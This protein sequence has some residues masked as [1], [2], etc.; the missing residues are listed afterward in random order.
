M[1]RL[2][3]IGNGFDLAHKLK[4][5]YCDFITDY[6]SNVINCFYLNKISTDPL[7]EIKYKFGNTFGKYTLSN[8][9]NA[10]EDLH[11]LKEH[12]Y[13]IV[14][15]KSNF[16]SNTLKKISEISWVDLEN[17]YFDQLLN[18]KDPLRG[19][20]FEKVK[21]LNNEFDF[22]KIQLENY[23]IK[24]QEESK[25]SFLNE[26]ANLF[27]EPIKRNDIATVNISDR[28]PKKILLLNFNYTNTLERYRIACSEMA[29]TEINYIHGELGS[30]S[31]PIIFGF[32]DEFNK[33]YLEF[34]DLKSKE[35]LKHIKSFGYLK[36]TNY[37]NLIRFIDSDDFQVYIFGHSLGLS[38][39]TMLKEVFEHD[40]CKSIKI[41]YHK[42]DEN[43]NDYAD[44]TFDISSHFTNKGIM[45]KKI[46]SFEISL[47][48]PQA[49][50]E[51]KVNI[52]EPHAN[53]R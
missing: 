40:K 48:M 36:T 45:R 43:F 10:L 41:F 30:K 5:S 23:L 25:P 28:Q 6:I 17:D 15:I 3:L 11:M 50:I 9:I 44:K 8:A 31:N 14:N 19:F 20:N 38:D 4:T 52:L 39:R 42:K 2:I 22:L 53:V 12:D 46:A 47:P 1:N 33:S 37:H 26:F 51:N 24:Q 21:K 13:V 27:C 35:L 49:I 34:E 29:H 16:L 32:G 7:I 18:Y